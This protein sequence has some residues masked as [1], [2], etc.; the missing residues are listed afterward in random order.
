VVGVTRN[1]EAASEIADDGEPDDSELEADSP[2]AVIDGQN[3]TEDPTDGDPTEASLTD[4]D[5]GDS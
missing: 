4:G 1:A 5:Q 2:N 3:E